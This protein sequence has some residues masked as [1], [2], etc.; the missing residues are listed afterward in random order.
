MLIF[1]FHLCWRSSHFSKVA[2]YRSTKVLLVVIFEEPYIYFGKASCI[3]LK[4]FEKIVCHEKNVA[5]AKGNCNTK[6]SFK[7]L[8]YRNQNLWTCKG[9]ET[10]ISE[11]CRFVILVA[12]FEQLLRFTLNITVL[13]NNLKGNIC[14]QQA[15][16][17]SK[18]KIKILN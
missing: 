6:K 9:W 5:V 15:S 17:C 14:P 11:W 16:T 1:K 13:K 10:N 7:K 18:L 12:H 2:V 8:R 3:F 4:Y